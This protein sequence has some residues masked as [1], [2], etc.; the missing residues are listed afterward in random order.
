MRLRKWENCRERTHSELQLQEIFC[1]SAK[2]QAMA[3]QRGNFLFNCNF[4]IN[5]SETYSKL[6]WMVLLFVLPSL[7]QAEIFNSTPPV[8]SK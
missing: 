7:F 3:W 5:I 2:G 8:H 1:A 6:M 4:V